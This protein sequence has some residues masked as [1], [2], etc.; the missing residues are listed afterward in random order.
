MSA[1]TQK[2]RRGE[3]IET[4]AGRGRALRRL[5]FAALSVTAVVVTL[6]TW[7]EEPAR[8]QQYVPCP[9]EETKLLQIPEL[10][11][12]GNILRGTIVLG[13]EQQAI[14]F[15]SPPQSKPGDPGSAIRCQPQYVRTLRGVGATPAQPA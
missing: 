15:R 10:A 3:G 4:G 11:A 9:P 5:L 8:A 14:P 12:V 1:Q 7:R 2:L 13:D 6:A